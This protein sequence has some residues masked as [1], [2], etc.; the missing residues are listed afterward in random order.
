[1]PRGT[2]FVSSLAE[3][4]EDFTV[5]FLLPVFFAYAGIKTYID[6]AGGREFWMYAGLIVAVAC[7]GKIGGA[8]IAAK[9]GGMGIRESLAVGVLM[10][11]RGLMELVILNVG[12]ELNVISE[13]VY[14][15]MVV[16]ALV[17][18]AMTA[19]VLQ[20]VYPRSRRGEPAASKLPGFSVLIPVSM[21]RTAVPLAELAT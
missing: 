8:S 5:V 19:P 1:M 9:A 13:R 21:P 17:T 15:M 3:K 16:M 14:A 10:N 11:T 12:R 20:L 7:V 2:N 6:F 18:T 4:I